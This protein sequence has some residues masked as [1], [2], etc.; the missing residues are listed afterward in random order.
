MGSVEGTDGGVCIGA[1]PGLSSTVEMEQQTLFCLSL[2]VYFHWV[3]RSLALSVPLVAAFLLDNL[4][5]SFV[6]LWSLSPEESLI[7]AL[8]NV[9]Y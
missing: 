8:I 1:G 3:F 2:T 9:R 4:K 7:T 6:H 5:V